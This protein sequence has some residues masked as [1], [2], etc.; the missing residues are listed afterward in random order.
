MLRGSGT[1][2]QTTSL[3]FWA[4]AMAAAF[5]ITLSAALE[6]SRET[7]THE[8][9]MGAV[10]KASLGHHEDRS[11]IGIHEG[12]GGAPREESLYSLRSAEDDQQ[13][14]AFLSD[15]VQQGMAGVSFD[16]HRRGSREPVVLQHVLDPVEVLPAGFLRAIDK[17]HLQVF[18]F[19]VL[20]ADVDAA[21]IGN[22]MTDDKPRVLGFGDGGRIRDHAL[23]GA[24]TVQGDEDA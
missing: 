5:G 7:K 2:W 8:Y 3:A 9:R 13:V 14:S 24:G 15:G 20:K 16:G 19:R 6:P 11:D 17:P 18:Q 12:A 23:G 10:V 22:D 4:L 1:T 21:K